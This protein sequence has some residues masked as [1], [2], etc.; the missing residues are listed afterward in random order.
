MIS[1]RSIYSFVLILVLGIIMLS[2]C[3]PSMPGTTTPTTTASPADTTVY[4]GIYTGKFVYSH[5]VD[6][7]VRDAKDL[8]WVED[9]FTLT[10]QFMTNSIFE[11]GVVVLDIIDI[12]CSE[13]SFGEGIPTQNPNKPYQSVAY[14]PLN[15]STPIVDT[16]FAIRTYFTNG[17]IEINTEAGDSEDDIDL[18]VSSDG[19][20]L[21]NPP[22]ILGT[23]RTEALCHGYSVIHV[24]G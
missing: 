13:P 15:T 7:S 6:D 19:R 18:S 5:P 17:A 2:G 11:N 16:R 10:L 21:S 20:T 14:L 4:D 12:S 3:T 24:V 9:S 22:V 8:I 1:S 23:Q